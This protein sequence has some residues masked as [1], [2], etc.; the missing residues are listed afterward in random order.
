MAKL[1]QSCRTELEPSNIIIL[2]ATT[3]KGF[4]YI[5][6]VSRDNFL[7]KSYQSKDVVIGRSKW[8]LNPRMYS[9]L[10]PSCYIYPHVSY[11]TSNMV[12]A[13]TQLT[14]ASLSL[15]S[16]HLIFF[17]SLHKILSFN[18]INYKNIIFSL[19]DCV[20]RLR[21]LLKVHQFIRFDP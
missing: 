5:L 18:D 14:A 1:W 2:I 19:T 6:T 20:L 17:Y 15:A 21:Q 7:T 11:R 9:S 3:E 8:S 4:R 12:C 13:S 16:W 10:K